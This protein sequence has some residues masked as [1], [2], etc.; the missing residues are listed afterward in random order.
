MISKQYF[1]NVFAKEQCGKI[2]YTVEVDMKINPCGQNRSLLLTCLRGHPQDVNFSKDN[3][4]AYKISMLLNIKQRVDN[5]FEYEGGLGR[6]VEE[7]FLT[8][9]KWQL[10]KRYQLK[11]TLQAC[12]I[13]PKQNRL[14]YWVNLSKLIL[15]DHKVKRPTMM[16]YNEENITINLVRM[17]LSSIGGNNFP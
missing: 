13:K 10:K 2:M 8:T 6:I 5:T 16:G 3:C 7:A 1:D 12:M 15:E 11:K 4:N 9:L 17:K 14:D